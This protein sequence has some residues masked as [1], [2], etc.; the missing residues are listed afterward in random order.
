MAVL[1]LFVVAIL[2]FFSARIQRA[3][4][5]LFDAHRVAIW[6]VPLLLTTAFCSVAAYRGA[7]SI[8]LLALVLLYT[9]AP[10]ACVYFERARSAKP[11][12]TDFM[13]ILLLWLPL[14]FAAGAQLIPKAVQGYLHSV[15]YGIAILLGLVLFLC[16]RAFD[17]MKY[18]LPRGP[19]D[20]WIALLGFALTAPVLIALGVWIVFMPAF[21]WSRVPAER[22]ALAFPVVLLGTALPEEILFRSLIQNLL[23]QRLGRSVWTLALSSVVFGA[24]HLDNGP[25]PAPNWRYFILATIAGFGYGKVFERSSTIFSSILFHTLVDWIKHYYF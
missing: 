25:L 3:A 11:T 4:R 1:A 23:M 22:M 13:A 21:H 16:F 19:R 10:T 8:Q 9:C 17:G 24:A 15:A 2:A 6:A 5:R 7:F 12:W 14:E 20:L 18:N